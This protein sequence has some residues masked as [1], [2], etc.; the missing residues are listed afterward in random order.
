MQ[1]V[2]ASIVQTYK[3]LMNIQREQCDTLHA[4]AIIIGYAKA[5]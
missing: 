4:T 1:S 2:E 5:S 3:K